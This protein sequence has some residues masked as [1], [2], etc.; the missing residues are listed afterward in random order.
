MTRRP[1]TQAGVAD[2]DLSGTTILVT[3]STS[4]IGREAA[5]AFGRLGADVL[6]HGRDRDAGQAVVTEL[7]QLGAR[8][9]FVRADFASVADVRALGETVREWTDE[10]DVCC[11]NA[12]GLFRR[13]E[14]TDLGVEKTFHVNH[15]SPYLMTAELLDHLTGDARVVTT[16][17]E[18][19]RGATLGLDDVT[20]VRGYSGSGAYGRSKLANIQFAFELAR[21]LKTADSDISSIS[22]H[23]G[24]IPGSGFTRFLPGPLSRVAGLMDPL[25]VVTSV[26][27]GAAALVYL[28]V[29]G[30]VA[31]VSGQYFEKQDLATPTQA[32]RDRDTQLRLW[33]RSAELLDIEEPLA[34][35]AVDPAVDAKE[36]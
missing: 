1:E 6:V 26:E 24:A 32:A 25:P 12:G 23:P 33:E 29:S 34:D 2:A 10:L 36:A 3:G 31:S 11:H 35:D 18:A 30:D 7:E 19:H 5:L 4:G 8:G 15:L 13:G 28:A 27:E 16:A 9:Q 20:S 22:F 21:R 17:S 14:L